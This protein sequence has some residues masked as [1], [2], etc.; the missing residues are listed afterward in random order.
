MKKWGKKEQIRI[1]RK[2]E[3]RKE[4]G[5]PSRCSCLVMR[6]VLKRSGISSVV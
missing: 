4:E 1:E 6:P 5:P 3:K 2:K